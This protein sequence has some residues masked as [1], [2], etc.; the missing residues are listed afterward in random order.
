MMFNARKLVTSF[1]LGLSPSCRS[2][3]GPTNVCSSK[4]PKKLNVHKSDLIVTRGASLSAANYEYS[5]SQPSSS[6]SSSSNLNSIQNGRDRTYQMIEANIISDR[7][8]SLNKLTRF[9]DELKSSRSIKSSESLLAIRCCGSYL[10]ESTKEDR[11]RLIDTVWSLLESKSAPLDISHYN[12]L[13]N[14]YI[15]NEYS[16]DPS[17]FLELMS[18]R[19]I[20]PNRV[21]YHRLL[22]LYCQ[23]GN[24]E[25]AQKVLLEMK[26]NDLPVHEGV[27]NSLIYGNMKSGDIEAGESVLE[28]MRSNQIDPTAETY[29]TLIKSY[30]LHL[31]KPGIQEKIQNIIQMVK[32]YEISF[33][34][35]QFINTIEAIADSDDKSPLIDD[36]IELLP[37][38]AG[39]NSALSK[40]VIKSAYKRKIDL[41]LKLV[42]KMSR[43]GDNFN[44]MG[45][46]FIYHLVKSGTDYDEVIRA[47]EA[48]ETSGA[49]EWTYWRSTEAALYNLE[50]IELV[51]KYLKNFQDRTGLTRPHFIWPLI[52]RMKT[53]DDMLKILKEELLPFQ[54]AF[55]IQAMLETFKYY[56]W[57]RIKTD[58][59]DFISKCVKM[60]FDSKLLLAT[61]ADSVQNEGNFI[62]F[63][64]V[65]NKKSLPRNISDQ[66]VARFLQNIV[67]IVSNGSLAK[68]ML[69]F[70]L[71]ETQLPVTNRILL[72]VYTK[73]IQNSDKDTA[74]QEWLDC[75]KIY[76][77]IPC[78]SIMLQ[79]LIEAEDT[80]NLQ[81]VTDICM[82]RIGEKETLINLI[83][84]F[85]RAKKDKQALKILTRPNFQRYEMG[86]Q[87]IISILSRQNEIDSLERFIGI[88]K[89]IP[90]VDRE[91]L[92]YTLLDSFIQNDKP[93]KALELWTQMQEE[94][95]IP[96]PRIMSRLSRFLKDKNM[97]VP[98]KYQ[99]E[100]KEGEEIVASEDA[101]FVRD[102]FHGLIRSGQ[103][104]KAFSLK[105]R[106][107]SSTSSPLTLG[108]E[109]L[110][111]DRFIRSNQ[112]DKAL[113]LTKNVM[114]GGRFPAPRVY[115]ALLEKMA[116]DGLFREIGEMIDSLP[117]PLKETS[118]FSDTVILAYSHSK[119]PD[120]SSLLKLLP[121][122][123]PFPFASILELL[124]AFP[125]FENQ[126]F[127]TLEELSA[128]RGTNSPRNIIWLRLMKTNRF[129]EA[130]KL[131]H[132]IPDFKDTLV[133][134]TLLF[135]IKRNKN[136]MLGYN[137]IDQLNKTDLNAKAKG[138][139]YDAMIYALLERNMVK[140]AQ[141]L[142]LDGLEVNKDKENQL[143]LSDLNYDIIVRLYHSVRNNIGENPKFELPEK[144]TNLRP[145]TSS[146]REDNQSI[147]N[148]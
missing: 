127:D 102:Q 80:E 14:V 44:S 119:S 50:D 76:D 38:Q 69:K 142:L 110:L 42:S 67:A 104:D 120:I 124:D 145:S 139:V 105:N 115:K 27:F 122:L 144:T 2:F 135:D 53:N 99:D 10:L 117:I 48:L 3:Y 9:I 116:Q 96:S 141:Q 57:P 138:A 45:G 40:L 97:E 108:D 114:A 39:Y 112:I 23:V 87:R 134:K 17:K 32:N 49:N 86:S 47:C 109:C 103:F 73:I 60:G 74:L 25:G 43:A 5:S 26:S 72:P 30:A 146:N 90:G 51:R 106:F 121:S 7:K 77:Q 91:K 20:K 21:T 54:Q 88:T 16:I 35:D 132:S 82:S 147:G 19:G 41:G 75:V 95:L 78:K 140:E 148:L 107:K 37:K 4:I 84:A 79:K 89:D 118:W 143:T 61:L 59:H 125:K 98:F 24:L 129:D 137:L 6:A 131:F 83:L 71:K 126:I 133:F 36:L 56:V 128:A 81:K 63:T 46:F 15:D 11:N 28:I 85:I 136:L 31:D 113:R 66:D 33:T 34:F 8:I 55:G 101:K 65:L 18:Q 29:A 70:I 123:K 92:Y 52:C 1:R 100:I 93:H 111:I 94:N 68:E 62:N 12:A 130:K 64:D 58:Q 22:H 13:L